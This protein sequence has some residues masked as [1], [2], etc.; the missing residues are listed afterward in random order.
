MTGIQTGT[1]A[2]SLPDNSLTVNAHIYEGILLDQW[3]AS[4]QS[5]WSL[6]IIWTL[7]SSHA[8]R[9]QK[10]IKLVFFLRSPFACLVFAHLYSP[11]NVSST[12]VDFHRGQWSSAEGLR[13]TSRQPHKCSSVEHTYQIFTSGCSRELMRFTIQLKRRPYRALD[14]ASRTSVALSTLL[15]LMMVSPLVTTHWEVSASWSSSAPILR[16]DAAEEK[17]G[18]NPGNKT[19]RSC[20][21]TSIN[22]KEKFWKYDDFMYFIAN[23]K[24]SL[25]V[26]NENSVKSNQKHNRKRT[27][28]E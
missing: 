8:T 7:F 4:L 23:M 12:S 20:F 11:L 28:N 17:Q 15:V 3:K 24:N 10:F 2:S 22:I 9:N 6:L 5:L 27:N 26:T 13:Q 14:M 19:H 21:G 25:Y 16:R 1:L 18:D